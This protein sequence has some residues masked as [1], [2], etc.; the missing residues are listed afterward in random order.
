MSRPLNFLIIGAGSRDAAYAQAV[1]VTN[2]DS[3]NPARIAAVAEP[4]PFK[5]AEFGRKFIWGRA[6]SSERGQE[7]T[8]WREWIAWEDARRL[9]AKTNLQSE[10][11]DRGEKTQA[12]QL[13]DADPDVVITGVF[14]CTLDSSHAEILRAL[15]HLNLHVLCEKPL[16]L[17]LEDC[18]DIQAAYSSHKIHS[19]PNNHYINGNGSA[20]IKQKQEKIFSIG[21][22]LRYS[23]FNILLRRLLLHDRAIGD[24]ISLE[25]TEPVGWWHFT[26]S[27]VRG[28]WRHTTPQGVGTL[29]TKSCHDIDFIMWL[30]S[31]PPDP[32]DTRATPH[33]PATISSTGSLAHFRRARKP[34]E[35]GKATNCTKCPLGEDGCAFSA[36]KIY[37]DRWLRRDR[38]TGWP[39]N[40][41]LPEIEDVVSSSSSSS[42][43]PSGGWEAAEAALLDKLGEDYDASNAQEVVVKRVKERGWYGRCVYE[44]DNDVIDDQTVTM[45][46]DEEDEPLL[47]HPEGYVTRGPKTAIFHLTFATQAQ[48]DRRGRIYGSRG[49]IAYDS[50][51]I[52]VYTFA[53]EKVVEHVLPA[54]S[55]EEEKNHGGGDIGLA[56]SF[57]DAVRAV[58]EGH[59]TADEAQRR[60]VGGDLEEFVCSHAVVFAAEEARMEGRV[61]KFPEW[62]TEKQGLMI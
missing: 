49:E 46:W 44:S 54:P 7:F 30:L 23:P 48:C 31:S 41:V 55:F 34:R 11:D 27:Y 37:R 29:L 56:R 50:N 42:S 19:N 3:A 1:T 58:E 22:V 5:R 17:R 4:D 20:I 36:K 12:S 53:D 18:L 60:F 13:G 26:H 21:H 32:T 47:P 25:H 38:E 39:L 52:T 24:V 43:D 16:A 62:W 35:A 14:V 51:S 8:D 59:M 61:V 57:V 45:T 40:I 33:L 28:N 10:K 2:T 6:G 15:A 9:K